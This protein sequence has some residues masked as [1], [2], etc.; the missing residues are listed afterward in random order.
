[1]GGGAPLPLWDEEIVFVL[2]MDW[3]VEATESALDMGGGAP[4]AL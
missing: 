2:A 1:M 4:L 3:G